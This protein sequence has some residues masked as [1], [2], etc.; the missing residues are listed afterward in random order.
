MKKWLRR[1]GITLVLLVIILP[2]AFLAAD[3]IWPLPIKQIEMARTVVAADGTPL[4]RFADKEGIWRFP[5]TLEEVSPD[6]IEALLTYEDRHFYR[7]PGVNPFS[8]VRAAGQFVSSGRIVSGGST[9][10]MQVAR[11]IDPHERTLGGKLKQLWR[12]AQLEYHY[13]K[14]EILEMYLNRAPYGGTIEG[15]GAASW[16]YLNKSPAK[17][18]ASEAA[19]F[20]VLPQAPSRLRPDRYP[21]RAQAARDKVLDRLEEYQVWSPEKVTDIKQEQIWLAP[22]KNPHSAPLLARRVTKGTQESIIETTIDAS[23]Q[24]QLEDMAMN[25]KNQLPKQTSLGIL[26]VDHTDMA[27]KAYIGSIDFQD[28]SRFGHVDMVSAWRSPGSTLKPFLYAL[29]MDDGLIHAESLLQDVP[30]RFNDYRPG[31]FDSGFNGPVSVS[32]A[33]VRSLNLPVVQLLDVYGSKRFT[34]QLRNVGTEL[35][36]PLGSEPNLSLILGGTATRMEDLVSAYSAFA[37]KGNVSPLRF[38]PTDEIRDRALMSPGAA[39]IVRRIMGGEARP[40]PDPNLSGQINLAWK[41]GTSYGYRDAWAIGVNPRYTIGVWVGRP[42]ATPVAGQLGFAT[43]IPIMNQINGMLL[44]KIYQSHE[45]LPKDVKPAS[46]S[47][48]VICWPGGT[49][50]LKDDN[51]CRQRRLSW[52]LDN[53]IPPT[54][55]ARD[56]ESLLGLRQKIWVNEKGLQVAA[57][58]PN[59]QEKEVHLW[60][61]TVESWLPNSEKRENRLPKA[62][63]VCPPM[64]LEMPPLLISG[65]RDG[66]V[67]QRLPGKTSLDLRLVTQGGQ[68]QKWWFLNGEQVNT[69]EQ[70]GSILLTLDKS[71]SYQISVLDL[72]GQVTAISFRVK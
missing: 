4:W 64:K 16:V 62:D 54:L 10:S 45:P 8:L 19:L 11:L 36:F 22:R 71:G 23:L 52:I 66:E 61:I 6:F 33:L 44:S 28:D 68:G 26:V 41:T 70:N 27:V 37:R 25:W 58:C 2:L 13:S 3:K 21:E 31:N 56:Q 59:A 14:D 20:A 7:H 15:I 51:N 72:S 63:S 12:T 60:P 39:W 18:T 69:T 32:D 65:I 38:K 17:L 29:A 47:Q 43:A 49:A 35:R 30:R 48:A 42:D 9:I 24:R 34:A 46:V 67:L 50:L 57:D 40:V 5:V 1:T 53:T 55:M